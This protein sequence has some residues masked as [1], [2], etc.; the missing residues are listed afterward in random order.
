MLHNRRQSIGVLAGATISFASGASFAQIASISP[1][2]RRML[3]SV[4]NTP[5]IA[6]SGNPDKPVYVIWAPWCPY[7][8]QV[9]KDVVAGHHTDIQ[10]RWIGA[11]PRSPD[12]RFTI[13]NVAKSGQSESLQKAI[14]RQPLDQLPLSEDYVSRVLSAELLFLPLEK[15]GA[16][17]FPTFIYFDGQRIATHSGYGSPQSLAQVTAKAQR[18]NTAKADTSYLDVVWKD[19]GAGSGKPYQNPKGHYVFSLP[20]ENAVAVVNVEPGYRFSAPMKRVIG[21]GNQ[22]WATVTLNVQINNGPRPDA[23]IRIA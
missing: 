15:L 20:S 1:A 2:D 22:K 5:W 11:G 23:Y 19:L 4:E 3:R 16:R 12:H 10:L 17:G 21:I 14:L 8:Q 6:T 9:M 13:A 7:C 18:T